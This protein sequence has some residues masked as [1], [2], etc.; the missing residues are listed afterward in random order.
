MNSYSH[1]FRSP[2][3][4][5]LQSLQFFILAAKLKLCNLLTIMSML[6]ICDQGLVAVTSWR[7]CSLLADHLWTKMHILK[8]IIDTQKSPTLP[9]PRLQQSA[10]KQ[11][12]ITE[13]SLISVDA[14]NDN[15]KDDVRQMG[16]LELSSV[17]LPRWAPT[18]RWHSDLESLFWL[19]WFTR[20]KVNTGGEDWHLRTCLHGH[21]SH[22]RYCAHSG[23]FSEEHKPTIKHFELGQRAQ[24]DITP[25]LTMGARVWKCIIDYRLFIS[26]Y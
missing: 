7:R 22:I 4:E 16:N 15:H 25:G 19:Y 9:R 24:L 5:S 6:L 21:Q 3:H 11:K 14:D 20:R 1:F 12:K 10:L 23:P 13:C 17:L 2:K 8:L 18:P 26:S